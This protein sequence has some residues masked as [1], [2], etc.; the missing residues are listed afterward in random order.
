MLTEPVTLP[1]T[2]RLQML[3][4][5]LTGVLVVPQ[6]HLATFYFSPELALVVAN[7]CMIPLRS[8]E[9]RLLYLDRAIA[10]GPGLVDFIYR[11][12]RP[13]A[14]Q[15]GQYMEWTLDHRG[16]DSRGK[17]RYF[18]LASS[19]T[20]RSLRVGVKF[21]AEGSSF[22]HELTAHSAGRTPIIAALVAGDFTLPRSAER[23]LAFIAG[24][25]GITPVRSMVKY[26]TD[27]GED[28]NVV[29]LYANRRYE[30]IVYRDVFEAAAWA[31]RFRPVY[32]LSDVSSLPPFWQGEVGRIDAAMIR[33]RI[34]DYLDRLFYVSGSAEFIHSVRQSLRELGVNDEQV[35]TD[36]FAGLAA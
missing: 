33:R 5:A 6:L 31:F 15:P 2:R 30:E 22:K 23:K 3:Y 19:P 25:I 9:K 16:V 14:Y 13:L 26:L 10:I 4:G 12:S 27:R 29:M 34:P 18:T 21:E 17:R 24:G 7:A 1:P 35:T 28:R 32:V 36:Y 8:L 20:E 11:P